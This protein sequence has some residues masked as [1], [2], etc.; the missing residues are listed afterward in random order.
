MPCVSAILFYILGFVPL[1]L[2]RTLLNRQRRF[3]AK[4]RGFNSGGF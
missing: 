2:A 4:Q 1:L 3:D